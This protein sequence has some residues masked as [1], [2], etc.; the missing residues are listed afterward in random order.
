MIR[1]VK[2]GNTDGQ[3]GRP[4]QDPHEAAEDRSKQTAQH[5]QYKFYCQYF[6]AQSARTVADRHYVIPNDQE[7]FEALDWL[8]K[9]FLGDQ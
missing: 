7:F 2:P 5:P 9:Q 3:G 8:G 4:G 6:L 1:S